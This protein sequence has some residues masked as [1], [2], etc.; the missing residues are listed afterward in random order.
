MTAVE[1]W[2]HTLTVLTNRIQSGSRAHGRKKKKP[3]RWLLLKSNT[4]KEKY[5]HMANMFNPIISR[6]TFIF[7]NF[8]HMFKIPHPETFSVR[9]VNL[10]NVTQDF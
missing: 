3:I 1:K 2:H 10:K 6:F 5:A 4:R 9:D 8:K 7:I